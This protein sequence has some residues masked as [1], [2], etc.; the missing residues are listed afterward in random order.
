[1]PLFHYVPG[2]A[3]KYTKE[4][5]RTKLLWVAIIHSNRR[6]ISQT[7]F[8]P[9]INWP[10]NLKIA[11]VKIIIKNKY[12]LKKTWGGIKYKNF[13]ARFN[14]Y[15]YDEREKS[16]PTQMRKINVEPPQVGASET[17]PSSPPK[18]R[19]RR[20]NTLANHSVHEPVKIQCVC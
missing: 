15:V 18:V 20:S 11:G 2:A 6:V 19:V 4:K 8:Q 1:M 12:C 10:L 14:T 16:A 9:L 17:K 13:I 7:P 3:T 5:G